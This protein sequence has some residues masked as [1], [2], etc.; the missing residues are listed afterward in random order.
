MLRRVHASCWGRINSSEQNAKENACLSSEEPAARITLRPY[1]FFF[2]A[3]EAYCDLQPSPLPAPL[4]ISK[5][6]MDVEI[7]VPVRFFVYYFTTSFCLYFFGG[8]AIDDVLRVKAEEVI[9]EISALRFYC[10]LVK[11]AKL[12]QFILIYF[13]R[14]GVTLI[15]PFD[16]WR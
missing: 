8:R 16:I 5:T 2:R 15:L 3:L 7:R 11:A 1:F 6:L 14:G 12:I 13:S 10:T 4:I 9:N